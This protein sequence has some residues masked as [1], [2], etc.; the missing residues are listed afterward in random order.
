MPKSKAELTK[1]A[2]NID[3]PVFVKPP[4]D[5]GGRGI[6]RVKNAAQLEEA[7]LDLQKRYRKKQILVQ[8]EAKG[9]DYCFCGLFD[10]GRLKA[11]MVYHN[12]HK[13]P[14]ETG[15][16]VVRKTVKDDN[17]RPI[18]KKL[19]KP[20]KWHGVAEIDF[21]WDGKAKTK[22]AILEVNARFWA[23]LDH[24]VKSGMDFPYLLYRLFTTGKLA[25]QKPARIGH[26]TSL[27]GLSTIARVE[28]LFDNAFHFDELA[29]KWPEIKDRL[30]K[31]DLLHA[32]EIF[33]DALSETITLDE[34]F[35]SLKLIIKEAK[36]TEKIAY[37]KDDPFIGLGVLFILGSLLK[38]G[39]LPPE[40][41]S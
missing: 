33:T 27:P 34:A 30:K 8:E 22:P 10:H 39:K 3:F 23:G 7:F 19:M 18:V 5:V 36:N 1:L 24:S 4:D 12:I 32:A 29:E 21:M 35:K 26:K 31:K 16:G 38:H 13:L 17:F 37:S 40:I 9:K 41:T 25:Y 6:S 28:E 11:S 15:A 20:L 2:K 14:Q